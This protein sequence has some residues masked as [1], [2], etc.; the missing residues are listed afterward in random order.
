MKA[1]T[2][3]LITSLKNRLLSL[4][5]KPALLILYIIIG[6]YVAFLFV[7][8]SKTNLEMEAGNAYADI[9]ILYIILSALAGLFVYTSIIGGLSK[10]STLFNMADVGLL[11][12]APISPIKILIY[13]LIKHM[14]NTLVA[15]IFIIFQIPNV[16]RGFDISYQ[17][18][19]FLFL[20]Y[21]LVLFYSQLVSMTTYILTNLSNKRKNIVKSMIVVLGLLIGL[22][23]F[24]N[25]ISAGRNLSSGLYQTVDSLVYKLIPVVGWS[26]MLFSSL[27]EG[28]L[29]WICISLLLFLLGGLGMILIFTRGK[30]DY[31]ED[32]LVSTEYNY[33]IVQ[34]AK[35]GK[36]TITINKK[37]K[38]KDIRL[39]FQGGNGPSVLFYR[40]LLERRR[41]SKIPYINGY[42]IAATLAAG[43][44]V[45]FIKERF[46][47]YS[48]LGFLIYFQIFMVN[49]GQ[50]AQELK[51]PYIY[52]MPGRS[53]TKLVY[54]SLGNIVKAALDGLIIFMVAGIVSGRSLVL[55]LFLALAY[56]SSVALFSSFTILM[57]R[58]FG[59]RPNRLVQGIVGIIIFIVLFSPGIVL[60][61]LAGS[62]LPSSLEFLASL[63]FTLSCI[64]VTV[65]V[66]LACG[67]LIDKA[68][69]G[70]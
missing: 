20:I 22:L 58:I 14:G 69:I 25:Y 28:N 40:D 62:F 23:V 1:L 48:V 3:L 46:V 34:K 32:V 21:T 12:V 18:I 56:T 26:V 15:S 70:A 57:Q 54:A 44:F 43:A 17:E 19:V 51:K 60:S 6:A 9:R 59:A 30:D 4:R 33:Q 61:I 7:I 39:G 41:T 55:C 68:E 24:F 10:G 45:H 36:S 52:L 42:T 66:F 13:G 47:L 11:F 53:I 65:L 64:G 63:P 49:L 38:V 8:S 2:Y 27:V 5:K 37:A 50:L 31:Y 16:K 35:E 29:L 67:N